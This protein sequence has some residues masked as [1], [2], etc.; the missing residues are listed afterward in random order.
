[1]QIGEGQ[2]EGFEFDRADFGSADGRKQTRGVSLFLQREGADPQ[3]RER[4]Y[5]R[6]YPQTRGTADHLPPQLQE[7][8]QAQRRA[9]ELVS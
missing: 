6:Q 8:R 7:N 5:L 4:V 9:L 1:M 2:V 3:K